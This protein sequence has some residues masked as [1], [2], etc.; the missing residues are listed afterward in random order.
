MTHFKT[1]LL[2]ITSLWHSDLDKDLRRAYITK[3]LS[4]L[5]K[6]IRTKGLVWTIRR[7]KLIRLVVTRYLA[8]SPLYKVDSLL[9]LKGGFPKAIWFLKELVDSGKPSELRFVLT[10]LTISRAIVCEAKPSYESITDEFTG[11]FSRIDPEFVTKFVTDFGLILFRPVWTRAM[12]F[13]TMKG[14][15]L[16]HPIIT[17]LHCLKLYEGPMWAALVTVIGLDGAMYFKDL[18]MKYRNHLDWD[19]VNRK[20]T[21]L[22]KLGYDQVE[23]LRRLSVIQDPELKARIVGIVDYVTQVVLQPLSQQLFDLLRSLPQDRTFT[24]DPHIAP[25]SGQKYHSLDLSNATD[26][27]PLD[28]Q[29]QLLAEMLGE[30]FAHAWGVLMTFNSFLTPTGGTVS[31]AVG[32]PIGARSS[33]PM[34]T[35]THHM[36][37]QYAAFLS[38]VY[39]FKDYILLGDD[40]V[41]TNDAVA[42]KYVEL[43]TG[44]GVGISESKSHTSFTTY[45]FAKRWFHNGIEVTGFPLNSITSTLKAPLELFSAVITQIERGLVPLNFTRSVDC[46]CQLYEALGWN[47]RKLKTLRVLL[48]SYLFTLRNLRSFNPDE[49]RNFF[50]TNTWNSAEEYVIPASEVMLESELTR[51]SAAVLNGVV[52]G[53][54]YRLTRYQ[55]KLDIM[56][57]GMVAPVGEVSVPTNDW[58]LRDSIYNATEK[59]LEVG[60]TIDTFKEL[61]PLLETTTVVDLDQLAKRQRKSV[62][63]LYKLSTFGK[64]LRNQLRDDPNFETNINQ[65]FRI[66]KAMLDLGRGMS[67]ASRP[68]G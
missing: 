35:L 16:G 30:P 38:G 32:Q 39:P 15:P 12:F 34:F 68:V 14:G 27:F 47:Q 57:K 2:W 23:S 4:L 50:A 61:L 20:V 46:V 24:Q 28:L 60:R 45:E 66:K 52:M 6:Y 59:L 1:I 54:T 44:L 21:D 42:E 36:V 7:I 29:K 26:R 63:I 8:G 3:W 48:E 51:V 55:A 10:L 25:K 41:I 62:V 31:Y 17:A 67:K 11:D 58:P 56:I 64:L 49:V 33:W 13:F 22:A 40:I 65:N 18:W 19:P 37:V 9:G 5:G 43:I 53:L